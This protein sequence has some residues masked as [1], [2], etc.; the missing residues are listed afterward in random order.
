M[1]NL[2]P[3]VVSFDFKNTTSENPLKTFA[4]NPNDGREP[5]TIDAGLDT[6]L[7]VEFNAHGM[8]KLMCMQLIRL[9]IHSTNLLI[10]GSTC[11]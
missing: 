7:Q 9:I 4:V 8:Y 5:I 6:V 1:V 10:L 3:V 11:A 2:N